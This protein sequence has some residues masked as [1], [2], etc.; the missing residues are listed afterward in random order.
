MGGLDLRLVAVV[1]TDIV[2]STELFSDLDRRRGERLRTRHFELLGDVVRAHG[3]TPVKTLGDGMMASFPSASA[4]LA[5]AG[6]MQRAVAAR[7]SDDEARVA[8]RIGLSS[9]EAALAAGDYHGPPVVEASRLCAAAGPGQVLLP[10]LTRVLAGSDPGHSF[11][12]LGPL[13]LKGIAEPVEVAE[14]LWQAADRAAGLRVVIADDAALLREGMARMLENQGV[15]VVAQA[16]DAAGLLAEVERHRPE[17][18]VIDIRMPPT[19]TL[20]GLEAA[21]ALRRGSPDVGVLLLSAH[22]EAHY[23]RRLLNAGSAMGVGYL[24]KDRVVD[25][26]QFAKALRDVAGGATVLDEELRAALARAPGE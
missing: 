3:G 4:A 8:V 1:F 6:S 14:L 24:A 21:E 25:A 13:E 17:A 23:A 22:V 18:A 26:V 7:R 2:S 12:E 19:N 16:G 5:C 15:D 10:A 9:G 20:E 11:R